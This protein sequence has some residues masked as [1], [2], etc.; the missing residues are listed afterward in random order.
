MNKSKKIIF[1]SLGI[2]AVIVLVVI[3]ILLFSK[4][5]TKKREQDFEK[6]ARSYYDSYMSGLVGVDK[7]NVT[8]EMLENVVKE[9]NEKYNIKSLK[10][11]DVKSLITFT[12]VDGKITDKVMNLN[13]E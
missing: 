4:V 13:C 5:S 9:K 6:A 8:I 10:K 3:G 7:A 2:V 12:I 1:I 11:C